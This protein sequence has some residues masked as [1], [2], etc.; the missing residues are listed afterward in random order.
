MAATESAL[1]NVSLPVPT[2][3]PCA[4]AT[5]TDFVVRTEF[6]IVLGSVAVAPTSGHGTRLS[7]G[8]F[9]AQL[10]PTELTLSPIPHLSNT[11]PITWRL[12]QLSELPGIT[13][14]ESR[15]AAMTPS[16]QT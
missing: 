9:T 6:A 16:P 12:P 14:I 2:W 5:I 15:L 8:S 11:P 7:V 13:V 10:L 4:N 3:R 1:C